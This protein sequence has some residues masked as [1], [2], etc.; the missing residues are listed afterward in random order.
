MWY[1]GTQYSPR[2][3]RNL[4]VDVT[5]NDPRQSGDERDEFE[6]WREAGLLDPSEGEPEEPSRVGRWRQPKGPDEPQA[7]VEEVK[8]TE[9]KPQARGS[10]LA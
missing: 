4:P 2:L 6:P 7:A 10:S 3:Q 9:N 1:D 5:S 8:V